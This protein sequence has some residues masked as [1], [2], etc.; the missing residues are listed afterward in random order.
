MKL[1]VGGGAVNDIG[2]ALG[3]AGVNVPAPAVYETISS[4]VAEGVFFPMETMF[5]FKMVAE[6]AK[7][8][9][10]NPDGMYTTLSGLILNQIHMMV[11][12]PS[13]APVLDKN[14]GV[15]LAEARLAAC[16]MMLMSLA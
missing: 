11:C 7:Y 16:G 3:V 1:R 4:G 8:T 13:I 6:L 14:R 9:F 15:Y 2:A 5:A 10:V 12:L